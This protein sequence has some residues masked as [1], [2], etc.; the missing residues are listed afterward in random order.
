MDQVAFV[1]VNRR[2]NLTPHR[3][4]I[5]TPLRGGV[6]ISLAMGSAVVNRP[7]SAS[8]P[9]RQVKAGFGPEDAVNA[10]QIA[11]VGKAEVARTPRAH[12]SFQADLTSFI[13]Q[14][15]RVA[16]STAAKAAQG[17]GRR[18]SFQIELT[19]QPIG[20]GFDHVATIRVPLR[21]VPHDL[22]FPGIFVRHDRDG[23]VRRPV[24]DVFH[25]QPDGGLQFFAGFRRLFQADLSPRGTGPPPLAIR[26]SACL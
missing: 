24:A 22:D 23:Q 6:M 9:S 19:A 11:I 7:T 17:L 13:G 21:P 4:P 16:P 18:S 20:N 15:A 1:I 12:P 26:A 5:L 8:S 25:L 10:A 14:A 2:S 3:R